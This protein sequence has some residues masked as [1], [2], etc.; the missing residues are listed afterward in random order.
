MADYVNSVARLTCTR[1]TRPGDGVASAAVDSTQALA[2][3]STVPGTT[4]T[5]WALFLSVVCARV[6]RRSLGPLVGGANAIHARHIR[7][8]VNRRS[9]SPAV[10]ATWPASE[11]PP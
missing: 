3:V 11:V 1:M 7:R 2:I 6:A 9:G 5:L 8:R 4:G 10:I